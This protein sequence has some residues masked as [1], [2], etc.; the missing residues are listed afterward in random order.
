VYLRGSLRAY[1]GILSGMPT[2]QLRLPSPAHPGLTTDESAVFELLK[3]AGPL[4]VAAIA[5]QSG[6]ALA[7]VE[8]ILGRLVQLGYA[9]R[10]GNRYEIQAQAWAP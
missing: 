6:F 9:G 1:D 4:S 10:N 2:R 7:G 5:K 3:R 8:P